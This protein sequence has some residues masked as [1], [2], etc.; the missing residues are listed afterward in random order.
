MKIKTIELEGAALD[1]AVWEAISHLPPE[2]SLA[3]GCDVNS[4]DFFWNPSSNWF[5][6]GPLA[7]KYVLTINNAGASGFSKHALWHV[8]VFDKRAH[9]P[10]ISVAICR[11]IVF[12]KIGDTV[13]VPEELLS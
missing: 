6:L 10:T 7:E 1:W 8:A 12:A 5:Q 4:K 9:G 13:D 2:K 3:P 11:A